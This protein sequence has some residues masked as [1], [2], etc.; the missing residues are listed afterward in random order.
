MDRKCAHAGIREIP[1]YAQGSAGTR[2]LPASDSHGGQGSGRGP[3]GGGRSRRTGQPYEIGSSPFYAELGPRKIPLGESHGFWKTRIPGLEIG[4]YTVRLIAEGANLEGT[5]THLR[6]T[7]GNFLG[8]DSSR[9]FITRRL[10]LG[11][12]ADRGPTLPTSGGH[13]RPAGSGP[14]DYLVEFKIPI[15]WL[16]GLADVPKQ[17]R[18]SPEEEKQFAREVLMKWP[19]NIPCFGRPGSGDD[20]QGGI[21]EWEGV[22]LL[23]ECGKFEPC[24]GYD[25][26]SP[27]VGNLSVHS[28]TSAT[29]RQPIPAV[30]LQRDKVY[31][32]FTRSDGDG[33]NFQRHFYRKLFGDS[34][35]GSV[36]IGWQ[37]SPAALDGQPDIVD[38]YFK[39]AKPQD[40]FVNALSGVGY[41]LEDIYADN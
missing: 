22:R 20:P 23:S 32:C 35:H 14:G 18:A 3:F 19:S 17:P 28:G 27:C 25:G 24:T 34:H 5:G 11:L 1:R 10:S 33:W 21:G 12:S 40:C 37:L 7:D 26:Y 16:S 39:R 36:P 41:I 8:L 2:G 4:D 31:Y 9:H 30:R 29:V 13:S 6:V 15:L 38:Y